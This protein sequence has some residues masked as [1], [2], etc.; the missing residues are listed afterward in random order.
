MSTLMKQPQSGP[1][2]YQR[3]LPAVSGNCRGQL[4]GFYAANGL[5]ISF[6]LSGPFGNRDCF[7]C[8]GDTHIRP[9]HSELSHHGS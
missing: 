2:H 6:P 1:K 5:I 9:G 3:A 4:T 8:Q 7:C